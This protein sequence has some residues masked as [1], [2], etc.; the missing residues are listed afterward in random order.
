VTAEPILIPVDEPGL[1]VLIGAA[2][3]G[4]TTLAGRLFAPDEVISS[5]ALRA[6]VSGDAADQRATRPAF[7]ILH[8]EVARRLMAGRLVVVDAT[9][10]EHTARR[11]LLRRAAIVGAPAVALVLALPDALVHARNAARPGRPVPAD[12]VERHLSGV[13]RLLA[14]GPDAAVAALIAEGF[15]A[16]VVVRSEDEVARLRI[17]RGTPISPR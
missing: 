16:A 1:V 7:A 5:D 15:A 6:A 17:V 11:D 12:V 9:S 3:A 4:K 10:I 14:G 8:R 13:A 2:G